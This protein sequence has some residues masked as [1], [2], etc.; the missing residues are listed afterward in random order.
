MKLSNVKRSIVID[1]HSTS[2]SLED[3]QP[4]PAP[5]ATAAPALAFSDQSNKRAINHILGTQKRDV[6]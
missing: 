4:A 6:P 2:I 5:S 1:G 3:V